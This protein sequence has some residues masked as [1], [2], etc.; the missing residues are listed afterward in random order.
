MWNAAEVLAD[1]EVVQE[2]GER[3]DRVLVE[4][5]REGSNEAFGELVRRHRAMPYGWAARLTRDGHLAEDIVQEALIRAFLQLGQ[6]LDSRRF[7][8]WL[9]TIVH[10]QVHMKLR[11]GGPYGKERPFSGF[12]TAEEEREPGGHID[13]LLARLSKKIDYNG[14]VG[15]DPAEVVAR[16]EVLET[17]REL[18]SCLTE[19]ERGIFDAHFFRELSSNEIAVL[20]GTTASSVYN[21]LS[22]ARV[23]VRQER[24]RICIRGYVECRKQESKPARVLLDPDKIILKG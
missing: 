2:E 5:A 9:K 8:P 3:P 24:I 10:N 23:K 4:A 13:E 18:L 19:K 6:L 21:H 1:R 14:D 20:F 22:R 12:V 16:C 15:L 7:Q 11:R 17:F